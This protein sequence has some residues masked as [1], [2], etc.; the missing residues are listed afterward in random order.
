MVES[1]NE[2]LIRAYVKLGKD[3]HIYLTHCK[4]VWLAEHNSFGLKMSK[5]FY[6]SIIIHEVAHFIAEKIAGCKIEIT[7][8]E[9]IA[10]VVQ[11]SQMKP[12]LR[13][14]ILSRFP[15]LA[16]KTEEINLDVMLFSPAVFS[17][18]SYLHF[19]ESKGQYTKDILSGT[20]DKPI[21][22][23]YWNFH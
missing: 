22:Y 14:A 16:F 17:V 5:D 3:D 18:R 21:G 10:D 7:N 4:E 23:V 12:S 6:E 2:D 15:L 8:S 11:L 1:C 13:Q 19:K 9:Y 20:I